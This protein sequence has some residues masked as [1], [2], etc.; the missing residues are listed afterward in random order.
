V[1]MSLDIL[2]SDSYYWSR[3][4]IIHIKRI[5]PKGPIVKPPD[6][7]KKNCLVT[8]RYEGWGSLLCEELSYP[9][10]RLAP[11]ATY[12]KPIKCFAI[13]SGLK[14]K[15]MGFAKNTK[16]SNNNVR[17]WTNAWPCRIHMRAPHQHNVHASNLLRNQNNF[18]V[19]PYM[20]YLLPHYLAKFMVHGGQ[21]L[22]ADHCRQWKDLKVKD[23]SIEITCV[24][25]EMSPRGQKK[26]T[27]SY[28]VT[29][30]F[31]Q[32]LRAA[33]SD[34]LPIELPTSQ[35]HIW[36]GGYHDSNNS[37]EQQRANIHLPKSIAK[38]QMASLMESVPEPVTKPV[39]KRDKRGS[40]MNAKRKRLSPLHPATSSKAAIKLSPSEKPK[41]QPEPGLPL[42]HEHVKRRGSQTSVTRRRSISPRPTSVKAASLATAPLPA[43]VKPVSSSLPSWSA[44][45]PFL[46]PPIPISDM[47]FPNHGVRYLPDSSRWASVL[48]VSGNDLF[49]GSYESQA[50]AA[51]CAKLALQQSGSE[52]V[53]GVV[54]STDHNRN[55]VGGLEVAYGRTSRMTRSLHFLE[56]SSSPNNAGKLS[57]LFNTSAESI[58]SAFEETQSKKDQKQSS[59]QNTRFRIQDWM[60]QHSTHNMQQLKEAA[61]SGNTAVVKNHFVFIVDVKNDEKAH[62]KRRKQTNPRRLSQVSSV[63]AEHYVTNHENSAGTL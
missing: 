49:V 54:E 30:Q 37:E 29:S 61:L 52:K 13:L 48:R 4:V 28:F 6:P 10:E 21:W 34:P 55:D 36:N 22:A 31:C 40:Q 56:P 51:N 41:P 27:E 45:P 62:T 60:I 17:N 2:D 50:E 58:V 38:I 35:F 9:N 1:N 59:S 12:T 23:T 44:H 63:E 25:H 7:T 53:S 46:P 32:A 47:A 42:A 11:V 3:G 18:F 5:T 57:D 20:A 15:D 24:L 33:Q 16:S 14:P 19:Q 39:K 8:V 43:C 26:G